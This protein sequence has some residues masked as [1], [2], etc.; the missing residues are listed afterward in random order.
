LDAAD[1]EDIDQLF[2]FDEPTIEDDSDSDFEM[3]YD[4]EGLKLATQQS[5]S[6]FRTNISHANEFSEFAHLPEPQGKKDDGSMRT[7]EALILEQQITTSLLKNRRQNFV[8]W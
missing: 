3:D 7:N 2:D 8:N 5:K 4:A 6:T 1:E